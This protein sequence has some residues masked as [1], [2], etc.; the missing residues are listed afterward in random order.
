MR[1]T[2]KLKKA[3]LVAMPCLRIGR[4][5]FQVERLQN[6]LNYIMKVGIEVNGIFGFETWDALRNFQEKYELIVDNELLR[7]QCNIHENTIPLS[8]ENIGGLTVFETKTVYIR[9]NITSCDIF[10]EM[11]MWK[12]KK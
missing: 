1:K 8:Y 7:E 3:P 10:E 4:L 11:Y 2:K 12:K 5:G 6:D 9:S